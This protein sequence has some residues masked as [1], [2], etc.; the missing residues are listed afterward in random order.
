MEHGITL[1]Q[2]EGALEGLLTQHLTS[3]SPGAS[4]S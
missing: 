3:V 1:S 2:I 4:G